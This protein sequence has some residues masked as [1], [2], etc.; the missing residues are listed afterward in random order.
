MC[1]PVSTTTLVLSAISIASATAGVVSQ[2]LSA[3]AQVKGINRSNKLQAEESAKA[4]G[5]QLSEEARAAR[6]ERAAARAA[7]SES[8]INLDSGSFLSSLA[9]SSINQSINEGVI[10]DNTDSRN[11]A[12]NAE[13]SAR[14]SGL[15]TNPFAAAL[16]IGAAGAR[17]YATGAARDSSNR[18]PK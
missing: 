8:G 1:E 5:Q 15:G 12:R 6:R 17:T 18:K 16:T 13:A 14:A 10:R 2:Q 7:A 3:T 9:T 4:A 11:A